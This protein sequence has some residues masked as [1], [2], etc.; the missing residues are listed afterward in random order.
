M[1]GNNV[2]VDRREV[3]LGA[4]RPCRV[5]PSWKRG[6]FLRELAGQ[7]SSAVSILSSGRRLPKK[8]RR[9]R[10]VDKEDPGAV[11]QLPTHLHAVMVH[12][13]IDRPPSS[14]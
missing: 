9:R 14:A 3:K 7:A 11:W 6:E 12:L 13:D 1:E 8:D 10:V 2:A 5:L 4:G